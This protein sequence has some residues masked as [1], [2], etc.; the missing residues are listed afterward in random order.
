MELDA[1]IIHLAKCRAIALLEVAS[2]SCA[3]STKK[4]LNPMRTLQNE[5]LHLFN[6]NNEMGT[7]WLW[8]IGCHDVLTSMQKLNKASY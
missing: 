3:R 1:R 4:N 5:T 7:D 6:I 2:A 8:W